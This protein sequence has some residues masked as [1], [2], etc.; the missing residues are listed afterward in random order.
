MAALPMPA[1]FT[2]DAPDG[3]VG[4]YRFRADDDTVW[5]TLLYVPAEHMPA[6]EAAW[7]PLGA[8]HSE[9]GADI[10]VEES[11]TYAA[12]R[13]VVPVWEVVEAERV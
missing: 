7:V 12:E 10:A 8:Y 11:T 5:I 13:G 9:N 1:T 6:G 2:F 3:T 4:T